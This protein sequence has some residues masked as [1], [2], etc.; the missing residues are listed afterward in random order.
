MDTVATPLTRL[1]DNCTIFLLSKSAWVGGPQHANALDMVNVHNPPGDP[2]KMGNPRDETQFG[3]MM[4]FGARRPKQGFGQ[5]DDPED[6]IHRNWYFA[7]LTN[8]AGKWVPTGSRMKLKR[9][10]N[11][12]VPP[13]TGKRSMEGGVAGGLKLE[14]IPPEDDE[15]E[16]N[17]QK[18]EG[19]RTCDELCGDK[20]ENAV[21]APAEKELVKDLEEPHVL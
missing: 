7:E 18:V 16:R 14:T 3:W 21:G 8:R 4:S 20:D 15:K 11:S 9:D 10:K 12:W 5:S 17:K 1:P 13:A 19:G 2:E 6:Q